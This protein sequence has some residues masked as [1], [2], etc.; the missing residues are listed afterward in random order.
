MSPEAT[1]PIPHRPI[2]P[3]PKRRL[4]ERLPPNVAESIK[5]PPAPKTTP[6]LFHYPYSFCEDSGKSSLPEAQHPSERERAAEI[7]RNYISRRNGEEVDSE[8]DEVAYRSRIYP[9]HVADPAGRSYR[10]VQ[11]AESKYAAPQPP[12]SIASSADGYD[13]FENTNN[14]KKRKIPTPGDSSING[15]HLSNEMASMG[16]SS[17]DTNQPEEGDNGTGA[18][19]TS[20]SANGVS[21]SGRG[22]YGRIRNGRSPLRSL[23][24]ASG[25]W[26]NGRTPKQRQ[27][28]WTQPGKFVWNLLR[29]QI[30][31]DN[32]YVAYMHKVKAQV[33]YQ[34]P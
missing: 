3:L 15:V 16:I 7:E 25:S 23:S 11:K 8:E 9:R 22:R 14:K 32:D 26:G 33:L 30:G 6:P 31:A 34:Q 19:H 17:S 10:Y 2:L 12:P 13:S 5:Y 20:V 28:G 24:D 27:V 29:L 4:R 18:H 21:G 1:S